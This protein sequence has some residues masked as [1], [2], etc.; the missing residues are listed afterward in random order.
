M[1]KSLENQINEFYKE[2][3]K[4]ESWDIGH[5]ACNLVPKLH[6]KIEKLEKENKRLN[7]LSQALMKCIKDQADMLAAAKEEDGKHTLVVDH[8]ILVA[9]REK[10]EKMIV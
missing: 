6:Y 4:E 10:L 2:M 9:I 1:E 7:D 5:M 3:D 8:S